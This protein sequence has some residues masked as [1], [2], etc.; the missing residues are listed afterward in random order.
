[1]VLLRIGELRRPE[2]EQYAEASI[3]LGQANA[4]VGDDDPDA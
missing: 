2:T 1:V 3:K 4:R